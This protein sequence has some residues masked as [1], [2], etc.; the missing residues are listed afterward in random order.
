MLWQLVNKSATCGISD[1]GDRVLQSR[2]Q[3]NRIE[4]RCLP[5]DKLDG[6]W[7]LLVRHFVFRGVEKRAVYPSFHVDADGR[8]SYSGDDFEDEARPMVP[9]GW[10]WPL[11]LIAAAT[12]I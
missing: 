12:E 6:E 1:S 8:S 3:L 11:H 4:N 10:P 7:Y 5:C 9:E 2:A